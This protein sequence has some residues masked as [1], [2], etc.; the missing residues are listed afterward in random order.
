MC[1]AR[2]VL[3]NFDLKIYITVKVYPCACVESTVTELHHL[4][5]VYTRVT[6][7]DNI[8]KLQYFNFRKSTKLKQTVNHV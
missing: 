1:S 8:S 4:D 6:L 2:V 3:H 5:N 7:P